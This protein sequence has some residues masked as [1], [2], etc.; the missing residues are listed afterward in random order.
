MGGLSV[1]GRL[2]RYYFGRGLVQLTWWYNYATAGATLGR[3]L[4]FLFDP[5]LVDDKDVAYDILATGLCT[6]AVFAHGKKLQQYFHGGH[7]GYVHARDMVNP[8]VAHAN[9]VEVAHLAERFEKVLFAS[10]RVPPSWRRND[11]CCGICAGHGVER[12]RKDH[13]AH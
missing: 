10:R 3:G 7:T 9:K 6:G 12:G 13:D 11:E 1:T 2:R 4:D 5:T 8:K